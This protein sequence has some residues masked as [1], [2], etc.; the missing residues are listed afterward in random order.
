MIF[1]K[2]ALMEPANPQEEISLSVVCFPGTPTVLDRVLH[3]AQ[4]A[5]EW[6]VPTLLWTVPLKKV[7]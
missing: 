7:N 4:D 3:G 1:V 6:T 5:G 2:G